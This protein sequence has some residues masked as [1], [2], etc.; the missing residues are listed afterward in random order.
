MVSISREVTLPNQAAIDSHSQVVI[1]DRHV[2]VERVG[3]WSVLH[4]IN[5]EPGQDDK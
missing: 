5:G 4:R 3:G 2:T 1:A